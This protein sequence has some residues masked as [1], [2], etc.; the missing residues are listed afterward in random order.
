MS[1]SVKSIKNLPKPF[2]FSLGFTFLSVLGGA[3]IIF[4]LV[5]P[6]RSRSAT[7]ST[8]AEELARTLNTMKADIKTAPQQAKKIEELRSKRD[9][10]LNTGLLKPD[11]ISNSMRM[12]AKSLMVPL[13][14]KTGFS[15]DGVREHA[16]V[17]LR[18][19]ASIPEQLYA[20]QPVEFVGRGSF[21][22][23]V[24]FI[25][26]TEETYP[27]TILSGLVILSQPQTPECHKAVITFEWPVKHE[28]LQ[29]GPA[30]QK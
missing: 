26:E 6:L 17:L 29:A 21:D 12:G 15:L 14:E 8:E 9:L 30:G 25:Q 28:W 3:A 27:L 5:L 20:R 11:P 24:R 19:P 23:I 16:A 18:L 22:Q 4:F 1:L 10:M 2:L 13:A 7:L